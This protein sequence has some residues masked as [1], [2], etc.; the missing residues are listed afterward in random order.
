[1]YFVPMVEWI[2][3]SFPKTYGNECYHFKKEVLI[4]ILIIPF[5]K[6]NLI[7][8][9]L[10]NYFLDLFEGFLG[11]YFGFFTLFGGSVYQILIR[12]ILVLLILSCLNAMLQILILV[13][14]SLANKISCPKIILCLIYNYLT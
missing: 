7:K 9:S 4:C 8:Y 14:L 10:N 3:H 1:M 6:S 12:L 5:P 2:C 13:L 11:N